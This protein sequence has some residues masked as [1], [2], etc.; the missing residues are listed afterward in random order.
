MIPT[1]GTMVGMY[2][3][4]RMVETFTKADTS[5]LVKVLA[6]LTAVGALGGVVTLIL[7]PGGRMP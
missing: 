2:I 4:T 6:I 5:V 1:I 3:L 7:S